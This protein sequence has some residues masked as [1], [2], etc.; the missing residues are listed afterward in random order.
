MARVAVAEGCLGYDVD[1]R[2]YNTDRSGH[3][4]VPESTARK[5]VAA[6]G[7]FVPGVPLGVTTKTNYVCPQ[8]G[9]RKFF[10]TCGPCGV[11]CEV[12]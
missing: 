1:G 11:E 7:A 6:G 10:R 2:R 9:R 12:R 8:C 4:E 5:L 3:L